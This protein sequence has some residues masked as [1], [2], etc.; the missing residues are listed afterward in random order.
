MYLLSE[1]YKLPTILRGHRKSLFWKRVFDP[2]TASAHSSGVSFWVFLTERC[3]DWSLS[4]EDI[5]VPSVTH[6][7]H[8]T[9]NARFSLAHKHECAHAPIS[10]PS[11]TRTDTQS[12]CG[13]EAA[14]ATSVSP[15]TV[16]WASGNPEWQLG[17]CR[18]LSRRVK[19]EAAGTPSRC[20][21]IHPTHTHKDTDTHTHTRCG[22]RSHT[23]EGPSC[24]HVKKKKDQLFSS[25]A[26]Q[27]SWDGGQVGLT[28]TD[29]TCQ[30][31]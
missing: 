8:T 20:G 1:L 22:S 14:H 30:Y 27:T 10:K 25:D 28:H 6:T 7:P 12:R 23:T 9:T 2:Y 29:N 4:P 21:R 5:H 26:R 24:A 18:T 11:F 3:E 16:R 31:R 13:G 15:L 19:S 17:V